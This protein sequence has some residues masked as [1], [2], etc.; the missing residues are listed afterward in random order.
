[1]FIIQNIDTDI[2][3]NITLDLLTIFII[4]KFIYICFLTCIKNLSIGKTMISPKVYQ[5]QI[6]DLGIEGMVVSP[7]NTEESTLLLDQLTIM[8][9]VL[10]RIRHNIRID[11]RAIRIEYIEKVK[12]IK[13]SSKVIG[14]YSKQRPMKDKINDKRNL[15]DERDLKIAP[16]ESIEYTI[17]EYIRQ[18]KD[19]K[20]YL[21]NYSRKHSP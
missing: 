11:I 20:K 15:I 14:L 4:D 16:Y 7:E 18:I 3:S 17:D 9:K 5:Q 12:E 10:E 2:T 8:E 19:A 21:I 13:D 6:Q 1:M